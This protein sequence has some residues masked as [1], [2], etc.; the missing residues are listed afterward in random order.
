M[1]DHCTDF[2]FL[3]EN[4]LSFAIRS[5]RDILEESHIRTDKCDIAMKHLGKMEDPGIF[6]VVEAEKLLDQNSSRVYLFD[7]CIEKGSKIILVGWDEDIDHIKELAAPGLIAETFARPI[8]AK[9]MAEDLMNLMEAAQKKKENKKILIVDDSPTFL[10]T[11]SEWLQDKYNVSICPSAMAALC[12]IE[13]NRPDLILLD[14]EMPVC[15]G[16]KFLEMLHSEHATE[17][18]PVIF[19]TSRQDAETVKAVVSLKPQ[20]YLLKNQPKQAILDSISDFFNKD[21]FN[22]GD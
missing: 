4:E 8:K 3:M 22:K 20:G 7:V 9:E 14:Y 21:F 16:G 15:S 13:T 2:M 19:L 5:V 17:D 11:A 6:V 12:M 1:S 10:R 18:I